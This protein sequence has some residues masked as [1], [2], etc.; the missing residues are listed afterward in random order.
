MEYPEGTGDY[1]RFPEL[2]DGKFFSVEEAYAKISRTL[3][4]LVG[5][6]VSLVTSSIEEKREKDKQWKAQAKRIRVGK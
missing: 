4:P 1:V 3:V 5:I 2:N 6:L